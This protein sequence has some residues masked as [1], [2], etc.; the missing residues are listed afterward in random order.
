[1]VNLV[2][3]RV[4]YK[5]LRDLDKNIKQLKKSKGVTSE[6]LEN[7]LEKLWVVE[8]GLHVCIQIVLDIGNHVLAEKGITVDNYGEIFKELGKQGIIPKEFAERIKG[9][10]G[11][12][13]IL[14]HEYARV[15][16]ELLVE[17]INYNLNDFCKFAEYLLSYTERQN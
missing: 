9:M 7:D 16:V 12:R 1:M 10:A 14:V 13:N 4:I 6:A 15:N 17:I 3:K 11:L 5:K 2:K 8:R